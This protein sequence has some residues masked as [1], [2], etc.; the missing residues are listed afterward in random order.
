MPGATDAVATD[1]GIVASFATTNGRGVN[2]GNG[3]WF[4][5]DFEAAD[6][7]LAC[8]IQAGLVDTSRIYT[9]GYSA[10]GLQA[11][12]M[13]AQRGRYLAAAICYSGGAGIIRGTP[14]DTSNLPPTLLLHGAA[15][16][17]VIIIDFNAASASW[18]TAYAAAGGL[19]ID[20]DDG[21][22]HIVSAFTRMG[23][24]G[25]AMPFLK[26]HAYG[27]PSPYAAGLPGDCPSYCEI[28]R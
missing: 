26:A 6:Q 10:G 11:C 20:C 7:I 15:G 28:V 5:G 4:T 21:G 9:A 8:G 17:D 25:R 27:S 1:G 2:T 13:V 24:G 18:A 23:F 16:S 12:A 3:V 14:Q 19:A 22:D